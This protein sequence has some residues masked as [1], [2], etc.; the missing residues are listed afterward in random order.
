MN[1]SF[2]L[3][4]LGLSFF[5]Y[6]VGQQYS[7]CVT[8]RVNKFMYVKQLKHYLTYGKC[9]I[10]VSYFYYHHHYHCLLSTYFSI[11]LKEHF[12]DDEAKALE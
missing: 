5:I 12:R 7:E 8:I 9:S 2:F 1:R 11:E 3:T 10:N 4:S 6:K